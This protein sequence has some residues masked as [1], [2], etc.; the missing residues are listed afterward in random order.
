MESLAADGQFV[1]G[2]NREA[3]AQ[4]NTTVYG[5]LAKQPDFVKRVAG[6]TP[7]PAEKWPERPTE[8]VRKGTAGQPEEV[9]LAKEAFLDEASQNGDWC[10]LGQK[11]S[12]PGTTSEMRPGTGRRVAR[13]RSRAEVAV[14]ASCPLRAKCLPGAGAPRTLSRDQ[15]EAHR[16]TLRPRLTADGSA[17]PMTRRQAEGER[18]FAVVQQPMGIRQFL[19]RGQENVLK[20]WR[21]ITSSANRQVLARYGRQSRDQISSVLTN[22]L[23]GA[24]AR[25]SPAVVGP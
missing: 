12:D 3:L 22:P 24:G 7:I 16:D 10:P 11:L 8:V 2:P 18:P 23:G 6:R 17:E 21:G 20:A 9:P 14:C 4:R 5:P 13:Q 19:L 25:A 15:S 1:T